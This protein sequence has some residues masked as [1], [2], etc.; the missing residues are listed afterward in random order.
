MKNIKNKGEPIILNIDSKHKKAIDNNNLYTAV[1]VTSD[2]RC[3]FGSVALAYRINKGELYTG[4]LIDNVLS[5]LNDWINENLIRVVEENPTECATLQAIA[6]NARRLLYNSVPDIPTNKKE[7]VTVTS[8]EEEKNQ[9]EEEKKQTEEE[10][11][12]AFN[13]ASNE[14]DLIFPENL[15]KCPYEQSPEEMVT[16]IEALKQNERFRSY[17]SEFVWFCHDFNT[18]INGKSYEYAEPEVIGQILSNKLNQHICVVSNT[19]NVTKTYYSNYIADERPT[20]YVKKLDVAHYHALIPATKIPA[21]YNSDVSL[22]I[23]YKRCEI[24]DLPSTGWRGSFG[25]SKTNRIIGEKSSDTEN[26]VSK[27]N[28]TISEKSDFNNFYTIG[29]DDVQVIDDRNNTITNGDF[30]NANENWYFLVNLKEKE[31]SRR[32]GRYNKKS[33]RRRLTRKKKNIQQ[34]KSKKRKPKTKKH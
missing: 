19:Y 6:A 28:K 29:E 18:K 31:K 30:K 2:G 14:I 8:E 32:G 22:R 23:K 27:V 4:T 5:T 7:T 13:N 25:S 21:L 33:R 34:R 12:K 26:V 24:K 3:F 11:T 17:H 10:T 20:I 9:T 1:E 16:Q 15:T